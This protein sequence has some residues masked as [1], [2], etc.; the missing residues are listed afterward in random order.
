MAGKTFD[1]IDKGSE[2][3]QKK[4]HPLEPIIP[5]LLRLKPS[6]VVKGTPI[7]FLTFGHLNGFDTR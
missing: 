2:K 1:L 4:S 6:G 5:P 7:G 3:Q